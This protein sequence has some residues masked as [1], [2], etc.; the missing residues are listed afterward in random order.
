LATSQIKYLFYFHNSVYAT[1]RNN[2]PRESAPNG[3]MH[4]IFFFSYFLRRYLLLLCAILILRAPLAHSLIPPLTCV[5]TGTVESDVTGIRF[6]RCLDT[7]SLAK[8]SLS[9]VM[10]KA[11][12]YTDVNVIRPKDYWDYESLNVQWG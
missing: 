2:P 8:I 9:T 6:D 5:N 10:S 11:R 12:V 3:Y 7:D 4:L 1:K